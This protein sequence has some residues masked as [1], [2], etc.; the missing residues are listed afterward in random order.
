MFER[1]SSCVEAYNLIKSSIALSVNL[2]FIV[3]TLFIGSTQGAFGACETPELPPEL[4]TVEIK[5][6]YHEGFWAAFKDIKPKQCWTVTTPRRSIVLPSGSDVD[7]CRSSVFLSVNFLPEK[8][9]VAQLSFKSGYEWNSDVPATVTIDEEIIVSD[10]LKEGQFAWAN[11]SAE[12]ALVQSQMV[13]GTEVVITGAAKT[14]Q[15]V[16]DVFELEGFGST[17]AAAQNA[18]AETYASLGIQAK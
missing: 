5:R 18:C 15:F 2:T 8:G 7:L 12:D 9:S 11:D 17:L 13:S 6:L 14:G 3:L 1:S 4:Q 16:M 10:M